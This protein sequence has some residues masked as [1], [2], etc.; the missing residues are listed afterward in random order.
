MPAFTPAPFV[1]GDRYF[2]ICRR[3]QPG[4][5]LT[6]GEWHPFDEERSASRRNLVSDIA[7][8][9]IEHVFK[10]LHGSETEPLR[11]ITR[12][13]AEDVARYLREDRADQVSGQL[14][15]FLEEQLGVFAVQR[16]VGAR[17]A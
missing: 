8:G 10:V 5:S 4:T 9:Q 2:V 13:I 17:A 12:D 11:D 1:L 6:Q 14:R 3:P 15:D 16:Y 7:T